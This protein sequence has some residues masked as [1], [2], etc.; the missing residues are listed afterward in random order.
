MK[1]VTGICAAA[2][3][4]VAAV[5]CASQAQTGGAQPASATGED[6]AKLD[7]ARAIIAIMFPPAGREA[8]FRTAIMDFSRTISAIPPDLPRDPGL[9]AIFQQFHDSIPDKLMPTVRKHLPMIFEASAQAYV[10]AFTLAELKDVHA[11]AATPSGSHYLSKSM[12]LL[13]DPAVV[14]ANT[15]YMSE[16][17]GMQAQ[18]GADLKTKIFA[19][20]NAH[21]D[22][23]KQIRAKSTK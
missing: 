3:L 14:A 4:A 11:F 6:A 7:E 9:V 21:P 5:P 19:Y 16:I 18:L 15:A 12:A 23:A 1:I 22:V 2:M 20:L 17:R 10:H 13:G 8:T